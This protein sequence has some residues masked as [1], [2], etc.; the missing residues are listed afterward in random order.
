MIKIQKCSKCPFSWTGDIEICPECK[1]SP[2][3]GETTFTYHDV[4]VEIRSLSGKIFT[5]LDASITNEKQAKALKDVIR[6]HIAD[7]YSKMS[8]QAFGNLI[9]DYVDEKEIKSVSLEEAVGV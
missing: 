8:T 4:M 6:T 9:P 2:M 5:L 1:V 3:S 7:V